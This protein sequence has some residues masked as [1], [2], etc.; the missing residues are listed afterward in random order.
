MRLEVYEVLRESA[1][2][3][4]GGNAYLLLVRLL[5]RALVVC[6]LERSEASAERSRKTPLLFRSD[7]KQI[8]FPVRAA[9]AQ[10]CPA[11]KF[12]EINGNPGL[13]DPVVETHICVSSDPNRNGVFRL[14]SR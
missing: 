5:S 13:R 1:P 11:S 8:A 14:R 12:Y 4:R 6:H 3:R 10:I 9:N 7:E 2:S